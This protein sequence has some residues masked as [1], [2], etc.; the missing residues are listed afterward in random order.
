MI[1]NVFPV[2]NPIRNHNMGTGN[3]PR[4]RRASP[5][6]RGARR[7]SIGVQTANGVAEIL[8]EELRRAEQTIAK[9]KGRKAEELMKITAKNG[10]VMVKRKAGK[11]PVYEPLWGSSGDIPMNDAAREVVRRQR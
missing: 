1:L 4:R 6:P 5:R 2:P 3:E 11:R 9:A 8:G 7:T 10:E